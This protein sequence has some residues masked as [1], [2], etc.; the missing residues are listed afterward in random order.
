MALTDNLK[1]SLGWNEQSG[2][3]VTDLSGEGT[4]ATLDG[5]IIDTTIKQVNAGSVSFDAVDDDVALAN[6]SKLAINNNTPFTICGWLRPSAGTDQYIYS[7]FNLSA[8]K[9]PLL[10][11][12][13]TTLVLRMFGGG[14]GKSIQITADILTLLQQNFFVI[15]YDGSELAS[16]V[17]FAHGLSGGS[18]TRKAI[19][20]VDDTLTGNSMSNT[21]TAHW[22]SLQDVAARLDGHLDATLIRVGS[23][24][25]GLNVAVNDPI[26]GEL[27]EINNGGAG[28]E[29]Q[30]GIDITPDAVNAKAAAVNP[31]ILFGPF[32][33]PSTR[34]Q[35]I[36]E[37]KRRSMIL[38]SERRVL[39]RPSRRKTFEV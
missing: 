29:V 27:A 19:T 2:G 38:D 7:K 4:D 17:R 18:A 11:H 32:N 36:L 33:V 9:G 39:K 6:S 25:S 5:A 22:G 8:T 23:R 26:N 24:Y 14:S 13:G 16:G 34:R 1:N 30:T 20:V 28:L 10:F 21:N 3:V 15:E 31:S 37:S 12:N 35:F